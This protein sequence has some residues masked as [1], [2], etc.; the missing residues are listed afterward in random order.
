[1]EGAK[2]TRANLQN[3]NLFMIEG[4][5][6]H[7]QHANLNGADLKGTE[8]MGANLCGADLREATGLTDDQLEEV[9]VD[10]KTHTPSDED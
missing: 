4:Q 7:L 2:L 9:I 1:M 5:G 8:F 10:E 3:A 6:A